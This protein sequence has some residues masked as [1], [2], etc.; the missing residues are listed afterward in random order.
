[1]LTRTQGSKSGPGPRTIDTQWQ[2]VV[3]VLCYF[4]CVIVLIVLVIVRLLHDC[5]K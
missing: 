4:F 2:V 3:D 1:M 5:Y